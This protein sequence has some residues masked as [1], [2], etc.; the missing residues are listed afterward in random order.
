M[1]GYKVEIDN[2]MSRILYKVT[3]IIYRLDFLLWTAYH[4][5]N[6]HVHGEVKYPVTGS[7]QARCPRE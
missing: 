1:N 3:K 2:V 5:I 4:E 6:V 7:G